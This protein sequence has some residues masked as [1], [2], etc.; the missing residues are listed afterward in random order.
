MTIYFFTADE[1]PY[2]CFCNFSLHSFELDGHW[3]TTS[4]HYYQAQK[5]AG[6][7][8]EETIRLAKSPADAAKLGHA[9]P[10]RNDWK[11]IKYD[12]MQRAVLKKFQTHGDIQKILL[13]T[14]GKMIIQEDIGDYYWG[15]GKDGSGKNYLGQIL[16]EVRATLRCISLEQ[17]VTQKSER[18]IQIGSNNL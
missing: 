9:L 2:G 5:F 1:K 8:H 3:W 14:G 17:M 16:M 6:T 13:A 15:T 11:K 4:E 7:A 10:H 12:V 18:I